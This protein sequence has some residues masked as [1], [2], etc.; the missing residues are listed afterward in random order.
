VSP[1][2]IWVALKLIAKKKFIIHHT[3]GKAWMIAGLLKCEIKCLFLCGEQ[4]RRKV[5]S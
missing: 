5:T 2:L 3:P 1:T 4:E